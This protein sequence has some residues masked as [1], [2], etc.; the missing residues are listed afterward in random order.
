MSSRLE[1]SFLSHGCKNQAYFM[2]PAIVC[3]MITTKTSVLLMDSEG[4]YWIGRDSI[5][6]FQWSPSD[7][8]FT[9]PDVHLTSATLQPHDFWQYY[10]HQKV[11]GIEFCLFYWKT[12]FSFRIYRYVCQLILNVHVG[13][14]MHVVGSEMCIV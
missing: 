3:I 11:L 6:R 2:H 14:E 5:K 8:I 12:M 7:N 9:L 1:I 10:F 13:S 4:L